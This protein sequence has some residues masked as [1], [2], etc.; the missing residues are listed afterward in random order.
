MV[1]ETIGLG[2]AH[3]N[4]LKDKYS[5]EKMSEELEKNERL[6]LKIICYFIDT[7]WIRRNAN[8]TYSI[9]M[10]CKELSSR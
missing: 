8:G 2:S 1:M 4:F 7:D 6:S 9:T 10:E 3:F 5:I